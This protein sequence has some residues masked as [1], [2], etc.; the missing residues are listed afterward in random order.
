VLPPASFLHEHE[1]IQSRWP[2][3]QRFIESAASTSSFAE[4][5]DLGIIL[6]GGMY[7][8]IARALELL[9]LW[10]TPMATRRFR[11]SC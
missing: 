5:Q 3:A 11:C 7:N 1:K 4:G 9:G 6:Q 2:A 8:T 10:P